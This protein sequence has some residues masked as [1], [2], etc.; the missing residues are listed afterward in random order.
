MGLRRI[1]FGAVVALTVSTGQAQ[2]LQIRPCI[3]NPIQWVRDAGQ[4]TLS[5]ADSNAIRAEGMLDLGVV[6]VASL[7]AA[8]DPQVY[9]PVCSAPIERV[10]ADLRWLVSECEGTTTLTLLR[11]IAGAGNDLSV[12]FTVGLIDDRCSIGS[13]RPLEGD[14]ERSYNALRELTWQDINQL[15]A[16][17]RSGAA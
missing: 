9:E 13:N 2:D 10:Y 6:D 3:E 11:F 5:G 15:I 14:V 8:T 17:I 7:I 4:H 12:Q 16:D 1:K